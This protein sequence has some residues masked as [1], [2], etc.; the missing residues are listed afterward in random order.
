MPSQMS[1]V[2]LKQLMQLLANAAGL[3][4]TAE[5]V[6]RDLVA[7]KAH[8]A[9]IERMRSAALALEAEPFVKLKR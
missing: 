8:L 7:Y 2:E 5:R 3:D 9:A 1:D 4:L 6:D